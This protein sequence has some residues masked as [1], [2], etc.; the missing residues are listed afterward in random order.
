MFMGRFQGNSKAVPCAFARQ[1]L[2]RGP[3]RPGILQASAY[4]AQAAKEAGIE[5]VVNMSQI[6][7][8]GEAK[9]H[10]AQ[11]HWISEQVFNWSVVPTTHLRPTLF[12]EWALYWTDLVKTGTLRLAP[13]NKRSITNCAFKHHIVRGRSYVSEKRSI[14]SCRAHHGCPGL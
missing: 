14:C 4:F 11:D 8:H 3:I 7:A 10:A 2:V 13:G 5:I 1:R 9:S 6:S 12:A